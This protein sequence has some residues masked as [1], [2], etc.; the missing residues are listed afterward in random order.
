MFDMLRSWLYVQSPEIILAL[1][2]A[3]AAWL[4]AMYLVIAAFVRIVRSPGPIYD[5]VAAGHGDASRLLQVRHT[6]LPCIECPHLRASQQISPPADPLSFH[7]G[8]A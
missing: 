5:Q 6:A 4:F 3:L 8:H 2:F 7:G 1:G